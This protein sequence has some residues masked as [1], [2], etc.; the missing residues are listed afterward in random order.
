MIKRLPPDTMKYLL[1]MYNKI[2]QE[3]E[4]P[5]TWKHATIIHLL[6]EKKRPKRCEELQTSSPCNE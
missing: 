3:G 2:W 1:D 6:K 5:N 4:I